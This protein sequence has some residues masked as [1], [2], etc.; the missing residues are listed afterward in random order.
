MNNEAQQAQDELNYQELISEVA[1][2][3]KEAAEYMQGPMRKVIGFS[4]S[5]DLWAVVVWE[6]TEQ[7]TDYWYDIACKIGQ[8]SFDWPDIL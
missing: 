8:I 7:G 5:G 3:D 2:V 6:N 4:T 1:L